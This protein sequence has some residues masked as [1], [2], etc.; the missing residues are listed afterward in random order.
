[1]IQK[2]DEL[3]EDGTLVK[4]TVVIES[5]ITRCQF[6]KR[7]TST[8]NGIIATYN[9]KEKLGG[10][11]IIVICKKCADRSYTEEAEDE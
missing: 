4:K 6:C 9:D 11:N 8:L 2:Y 3:L 5:L 7:P 10:T 1:M